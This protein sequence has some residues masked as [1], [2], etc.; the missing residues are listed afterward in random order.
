MLYLVMVALA[1]AVFAVFL[2]FIQ[3][4]DRV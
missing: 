1:L 3:F 4:C 2:G